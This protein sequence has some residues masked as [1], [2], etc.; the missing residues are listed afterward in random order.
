[1]SLDSAK[2]TLWNALPIRKLNTQDYQCPGNHNHSP[3]LLLH[4]YRRP[5]EMRLHSHTAISGVRPARSDRSGMTCTAQGHGCWAHSIPILGLWSGSFNGRNRGRWL[6]GLVFPRNARLSLGSLNLRNKRHL[7]RSKL[8]SSRLAQ[9]NS[10]GS[11]DVENHVVHIA[12]CDGLKW[13]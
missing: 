12:L 2:P 6:Q 3:L 9:L 10:R 13:L 11:A 5:W 8:S 7:H 1:M 4:G